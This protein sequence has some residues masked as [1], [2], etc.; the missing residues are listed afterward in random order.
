MASWWLYAIIFLI[1]NL[2]CKGEPGQPGNPGQPG[3]P[4]V[5]NLA[6]PPEKGAKGDRGIEG[7][8]GPK[9]EW[10]SF[11]WSDK[12]HK[13][14]INYVV[15]ANKL[16]TVVGTFYYVRFSWNISIFESS[17]QFV[18]WYINNWMSCWTVS[19]IDFLIF[20]GNAGP[21]GLAGY[22]GPRGGNG[23]KGKIK[24]NY[25]VCV[26]KS[27]EFKLELKSFLIF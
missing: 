23:P 18:R 13:M 11:V 25:F 9:G 17:T 19:L 20:I 14:L 2:L 12:L 5:A 24:S 26:L 3:L 16:L 21:K 15:Y 6:I 22:P 8:V 27:D 4:A 10:N 1:F 7:R